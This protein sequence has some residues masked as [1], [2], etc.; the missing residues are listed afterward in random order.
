[1]RL[2]ILVP[3]VHR[4]LPAFLPR[5]GGDGGSSDGSGVGGKGNR[6]QGRGEL[7][8]QVPVNLFFLLGFLIHSVVLK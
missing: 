5:Q 3:S 4:S 7:Y 8:F 6:E 2:V 1:M